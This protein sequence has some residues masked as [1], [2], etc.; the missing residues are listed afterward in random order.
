M[1]I[2]LATLMQFQYF[3]WALVHPIVWSYNL[4]N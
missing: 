2:H 4:T 3:G 1:N